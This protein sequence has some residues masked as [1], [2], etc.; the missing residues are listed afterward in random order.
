MT[1]DKTE[2]ETETET[3]EKAVNGK[4]KDLE[5][6]YHHCMKPAEYPKRERQC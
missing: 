2:A 6:K 5:A 3:K 4:D 1:L